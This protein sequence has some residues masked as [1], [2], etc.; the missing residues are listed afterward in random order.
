MDQNLLEV[1]FSTPLWVTE[2]TK[3]KL[4]AAIWND[5]LFLSKLSE[6]IFHTTTADSERCYGLFSPLR[7][8]R[9]QGT[10]CRGHHRLH[11]K[12]HVGQTT[13]DV[14]EEDGTDGGREKHSYGH[15]AQGVQEEVRDRGEDSDSYE[16]RFRDAMAEYFVVVPTKQTHYRL[17]SIQDE[18]Q[19]DIK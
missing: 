12:V 11:S 6:T 16:I 7:H 1:M 15:I 17:N 9:Q 10:V 2:R 19:D 18:S 13:G 3:A 5:S 14:G 8:R 4:T